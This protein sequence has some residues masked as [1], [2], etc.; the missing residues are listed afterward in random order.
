[1][2]S[3]KIL[4]EKAKKFI[5]YQTIQAQLGWDF[6]TYMPLKSGELRGNQLAILAGDIHK[7]ITDPEIG[8]LLETIKSDSNY[9]SMSEE[10]KRNIYLI[11][12]V[13][14]RQTKI[15]RELLNN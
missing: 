6:E 13:Y 15:P 8:Q 10:E 5:I 4:L 11:E 12:K 9:S 3:Y 1:M 7:I 2:E 14:N